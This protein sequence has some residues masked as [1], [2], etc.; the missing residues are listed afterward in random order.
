MAAT[1]VKAARDAVKNDEEITL[2]GRIGG[3]ENPW[4]DGQAAF[5]IVDSAL[6]PC[7]EK[8][9]DACQTPWDYCCDTDLL[10]TN[11]AFVK[12]V[13]EDGRPVP[14]DARQLLGIKELQTVVVH[15]RAKRDDAGNLTVLADG[16]YVR[17]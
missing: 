6:K 14:T 8:D 13:G 4:V 9:D 15:G 16:V 10:P 11:K 2:V 3:A 12:I 7:N 17:N 5:T 1:D